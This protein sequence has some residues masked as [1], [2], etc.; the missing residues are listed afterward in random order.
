M[1]TGVGL[2]LDFNIIA[3][4]FDFG[5]PVFNPSMPIDNRWYSFKKSMNNM[6]FNFGIGYPF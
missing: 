3:I 6:N 1:G 4:R 5:F 2:R